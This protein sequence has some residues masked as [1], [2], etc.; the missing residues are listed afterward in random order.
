MTPI[1]SDETLLNGLR[2]GRRDAFER[3]YGEYNAPIYNLCARVVCDR[4]EAKDLTQ[5]VFITAFNQLRDPA[6][7]PVRK[8]RPWLYRV[9]TNA[10]YNHLRSRKHLDGGGDAELE[11][12]ASGVDEYERAETVALVEESLGRAERAL[13]HRPRAQG[14]PG[15]RAG[16]DRRGH[17]G[18]AAERR[19]A[20]A[21][22]P[23][24]VQDRLRQARRRRAG[25]GRARPRA[26]AAQPAGGAA[27][28]AVVRAPGGAARACARAAPHAPVG[29]GVHVPDLSHAGPAGAGGLLA[30]IGAALTTKIGITAA[31]ATLVIGGTVA[32]KEVQHA[33]RPPVDGLAR[34]RLAG[35][36][37]AAGASTGPAGASTG[38][39]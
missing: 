36:L 28:D 1:F 37:L 35:A 20:R 34:P 38:T 33:R 23:R 11:N 25:A 22:R 14:P 26:P 9:A 5:D 27:G 16:G 7:E 18:L 13:P 10:C 32:V 30:K 31:A 3:L 29:H 39:G 8:L 2:A 15:P 12:A 24:L 19:R 4:E 17:G 6:A 21:P